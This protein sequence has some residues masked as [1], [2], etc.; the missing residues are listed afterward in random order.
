MA[1]AAPRVPPE[2]VG[3]KEMGA[4]LR[5]ERKARKMTL[6]DLS[7][8]SGIAVSTISKA[9]LGQIALSYEKFASLARGLDIDM[10]RLFMLGDSPQAEV[11]P[12]YV[13]ATLDEARDYVTEN[14]HYRLL[15]G[16]Y[17]GKKMT[18]ML[19]IIDSRSVDEFDDY[20]RHPGQEFVVVLSGKVRIQ[21]EN[22]ESVVLQRFE[23]AYF[24]SSMG[25]VYLTL[26]KTPAQVLAVC[27][28]L[29]E[30]PQGRRKKR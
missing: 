13:K 12:T 8:A 4:R 2:I 14:Y 17:P 24:D 30:V 7:R 11:P 22:G 26:S 9:E 6:H 5:A 18:P 20:I 19:G 21:F 16:E 25:H 27:T 10:T 1:P 3:K 23:S 15:L 29:D 28:D